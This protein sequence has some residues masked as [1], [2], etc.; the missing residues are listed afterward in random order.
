[1]KSGEKNLHVRTPT[2]ETGVNINVLYS[3]QGVKEYY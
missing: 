3:F 2:G 1:M